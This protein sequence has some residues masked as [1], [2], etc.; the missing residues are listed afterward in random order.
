M[1]QAHAHAPLIITL[2]EATEDGYLVA[3][4]AGG[5]ALD[6]AMRAIL[7]LDP[8][9]RRWIIEEQAWWIADEAITRLT[10]RL[11][12]LDEALTRWHQRPI[13]IAEIIARSYAAPGTR[14]Y[15]RSEMRARA[16]RVIVPH[17]VALAY[18][19]LGLA[20]GAPLD[21]VVAAR[22]SLARRHHPD[23]GGEHAAMVAINSAAETVLQWLSQ[24]GEGIRQTRS[25]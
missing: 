7:A 20:A 21:A 15:A 17:A 5:A 9:Q 3:F 2:F 1:A 13:D 8:W 24:Q 10:R 19:R 18:A 14:A 6:G 11:P 16:P 25:G 4:V 12:A 23:A 22:R